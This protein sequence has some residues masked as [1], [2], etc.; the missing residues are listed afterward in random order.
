LTVTNVQPTNAGNYSVVVT[1]V[2]GSVTSSN[3]LLTLLTPP[4]ITTQPTNQTVAQGSNAMF[5]VTATGT[6]PLN[7]QWFFNSGVLTNATNAVLTLTGVTTNQAGT[8]SVTVT[9]VA[10]GVA[11]SNAVLTVLVAPSITA[12]PTN[13]TVKQGNNAVFT[14]TAAG[15]APLSYR[16][17]FNGTNT[18]MGATNYSLTVTNVQ[19]TNAGN[20]SVVVTNVVG[21]VTSSNAVLALFTPPAITVQPVGTTTNVGSNATFSVTATGSAP[22]N[23]QWYFNS[24]V[25]ANATNTALT[26]TGVTTN[27]AGTYS[28]TVTNV[29]GSVFSSNAV[30]TVLVAPS[31]TAQPVSATINVGSNVVFTVTASGTTPLSYQWLFNGTNTLAGATNAVLMVTNVQPTSA[32]TYSVVVTNVVGSVTSSNA[33]LVLLIPP[34][35]TVQPVNVTTNVGSNAA[36][37]V[38]ATGTAPLYYQWY[39]NSGALANATSAV[40]TMTGVTANQAGAYSVTVTN[41]AGSLSS[42]NAV[43]T[44]LV[45]PSITAQPTNQIVTAGGTVTFRVA[46]SGPGPFTYQWQLNG[47]N[48]P[49]GMITTVAGIYTNDGYGGYSGDGG[50]ATNAGLSNPNGVAVDAFGNLFIA[51]TYNSRI[52]KV[53]PTG[54]ITTVAGNGTNGYSG[55]GVAATNARLYW[56]PV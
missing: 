52:R 50:A 20:Y 36:F 53:D 51:D 4:V 27:Q 54:M 48:L 33:V 6:P 12:Q 37:G 40:L 31:I 39:F 13:Q 14:V 11:S 46:V 10:G 42:S 29:A 55:D 47:T 3:A 7:Y 23:Y 44:V 30:L 34:A 45:A 49:S 41:V 18:L 24:G 16:W 28:V 25:L 15:T 8:Y 1:N 32:G 17:F 2:V 9:N 21:S 26:L 43:L 19:P 22:L 56:L 35:I 38:T 5:S